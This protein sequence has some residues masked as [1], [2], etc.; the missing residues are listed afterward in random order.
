MLPDKYKFLETIGVL[1]KITAAS[2]QL[3][4]IKEVP[5][6]GS[7][8]LIMAM[9]KALGID[10]IYT[11]DD[12]SWCAVDANYVNLIAGKPMVDVKGDR[13]NLMRAKWLLHWGNPVTTGD[14]RLGDWLIIDRPGGGHVTQYIAE[15][16]ST[17]HGLGGNQSNQ[18]GFSEIAKARVIGVRRYYATAMPESAK[19]YIID[20]SGRLSSNEA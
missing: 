7:N 8:P 17:F 2:L 11:D 1:P 12:M 19:K 15:S 3:L 9:A 14:E 10:D 6:K 16:G 13:Y 18:H 5:G 4:G 20:T